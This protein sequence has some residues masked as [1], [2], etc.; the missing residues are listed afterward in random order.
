MSTNTQD[1]IIIEK[2]EISSQGSSSDIYTPF[3]DIPDLFKSSK[4]LNSN[5]EIIQEKSNDKYDWKT[6][7]DV[8]DQLRSLNKY[9]GAYF[10]QNLDFFTTF[11]QKSMNSLRSNLSKNALLLVRE[12]F[13]QLGECN[14][15]YDFL[16]AIINSTVDRAISEK[17]FI[18]NEAKGALKSLEKNGFNDATIQILCEKSFDKNPTIGELCFLTLAEIAKEGKENLLEKLSSVT[19]QILFETVAKGV[20]GK[21]SVIIK[22]AEGMCQLFKG[23]FPENQ[24]NFENFLRNILKLKDSDANTILNSAKEKKSRSSKSDFASFIKEAKGSREA[25]KSDNF[26]GATIE[27]SK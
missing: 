3:E 6:H 8:I 1:M 2:G 24:Q 26:F 7:F 23:A 19:L 22:A 25:E 5:M 14:P 4:D 27:N 9:Y 10:G 18:K 20:N 16:K 15:S 13:Q 11:V 17:A 21:R 12:I